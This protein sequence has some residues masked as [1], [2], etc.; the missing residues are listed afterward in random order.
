MK[1]VNVAKVE[2]ERRVVIIYI[3]FFLA[4]RCRY[5]GVCGERGEMK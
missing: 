4:G 2:T 3:H 5:G 1:S